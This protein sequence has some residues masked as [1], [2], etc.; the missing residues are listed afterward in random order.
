MKHRRINKNPAYIH[1][2]E[3]GFMS[4]IK[5]TVFGI[6]DGMVSTLGALTGIAAAT[7]DPGM[8]LLAGFV[9]I[10]VESISMG[11]GSYVSS[12]S[13]KEVVE[14]M[15]AEEKEE[16]EIFPKE[17]Q[18]ELYDMYIAGGWP[19]ALA[20]KMAETA[21]KNNALFLQE[22]AYRELGIVPEN[23]VHPLKNGLV[24]GVSYIVGG[25]VPLLPYLF[26]DVHLA[27]TCSVLIAL[28]GLFILGAS[29]T[30]YTKRPWFKAGLEMLILA[31]LATLVGYGVGQI[32]NSVVI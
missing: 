21:A 15:L 30:V 6:E 2:K 24:M 13:E 16:I 4:T 25:T 7:K 11:V 12:K 31:G 22:M 29:I 17:E 14:R 3:F 28:M 23:G 18:E 8:V 27:I 19:K 10:A 1:H 20:K 9:V 26:L 32:M 5:E